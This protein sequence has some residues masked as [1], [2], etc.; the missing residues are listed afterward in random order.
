MS[1][2]TQTITISTQK[3][4]GFIIEAP[5]GTAS[6][7]TA[8]DQLDLGLGEYSPKEEQ[9][10]NEKE[11]SLEAAKHVNE[12][13]V[14]VAE[15]TKTLPPWELVDKNGKVK[16]VPLPMPPDLYEKMFWLTQNLGKMSFQKLAIEGTTRL[17]DELI[18]KH[19]RSE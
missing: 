8:N 3:I 15:V 4:R 6:D 14:P 2:N 10:T 1:K 7:L 18:D 16:A 19:Y 12:V 5:A 13:I 17:V 9:A 11:S